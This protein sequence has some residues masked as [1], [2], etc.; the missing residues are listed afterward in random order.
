LSN[1]ERP[2]RKA[3]VTDT[4]KPI[5]KDMSDPRH[6]TTLQAST[7]YYRDNST[8]L[9]ST[10][11]WFKKAAETYRVNTTTSFR[12]LQEKNAESRRLV[13]PKLKVKKVKLSP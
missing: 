10:N 13:K 7:T 3:D 2:V 9:L 4:Y 1:E 8:S 11:I 12:F 6:F 5:V